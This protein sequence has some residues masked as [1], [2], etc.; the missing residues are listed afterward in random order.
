MEP[1]KYYT[2]VESRTVSVGVHQ[3]FLDLGRLRKFAGVMG[4]HESRLD[5][6]ELPLEFGDRVFG[7]LLKNGN[8]RARARRLVRRCLGKNPKL[9]LTKVERRY[10]GGETNR[11]PL[12]DCEPEIYALLKNSGL[13]RLYQE[14]I[15]LGEGNELNE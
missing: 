9:K 12:N 13:A 15:V 6:R 5:P 8:T 1:V 10:L 11:Y 2:G 7:Y 4:V 3:S 14:S